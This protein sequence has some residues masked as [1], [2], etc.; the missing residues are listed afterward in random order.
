[1][2]DVLS[3]LF[4]FS[5]QK[6]YFHTSADIRDAVF[7]TF[8]NSTSQEPSMGGQN[9]FG[10]W[11]DAVRIWPDFFHSFVWGFQPFIFLHWHWENV[12]KKVWINQGFC[13]GNQ[14]QVSSG[15]PVTIIIIIILVHSFRKQDFDLL[16]QRS[17]KVWVSISLYKNYILFSLITTIGYF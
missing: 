13:F 3:L 2:A 7:S 8:F 9:Y 12:D 11:S 14:Q 4:V 16:L 15:I 10:N 6:I 1:M 17:I 5:E